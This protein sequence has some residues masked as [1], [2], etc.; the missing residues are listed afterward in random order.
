MA[1]VID[2]IQI[3]NKRFGYEVG[4][5]IMRYFAGFLKAQLQPKDQMFRWTGPTLAG[6]VYR[7]NR[8][9]GSATRSAASWR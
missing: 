3:L 4:D 1:V 7:P 5:E 6:L 9:E 2:R 8:L